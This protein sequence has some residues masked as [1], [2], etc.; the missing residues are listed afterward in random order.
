MANV[1]AA[2]TSKVIPGD[3]RH[4]DFIAQ[5]PEFYI[6]DKMHFNSIL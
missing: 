6:S 3:A 4:Q 1:F 2:Q 5:H